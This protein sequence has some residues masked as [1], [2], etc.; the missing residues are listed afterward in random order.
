MRHLGPHLPDVLEYHIRVPVE[1]LH[2]RKDFPVV[3]AI[4]QHLGIV[5]DALLQHGEWP[6]I[7]VV[8]VLGLRLV[9]HGGAAG[10]QGQR[11]RCLG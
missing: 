1:G 3:A 7:E 9:G 10:G 8:L 5:L 11:E 2:T 6:D 4:N